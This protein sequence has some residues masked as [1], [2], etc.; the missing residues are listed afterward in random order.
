MQQEQE[1]D[2]DHEQQA[3]QEL[4]DALLHAGDPYMSPSPPASPTFTQRTLG[5][6]DEWEE[7]KADEEISSDSTDATAHTLTGMK[8]KGH[9][10]PTPMHV[11]SPDA[12]EHDRDQPPHTSHLYSGWQQRGP[13]SISYDPTPSSLTRPL[14][15]DSSGG[16][17]GLLPFRIR[18][19]TYNDVKGRWDEDG[20]GAIPSQQQHGPGRY[21]AP[22]RN[23]RGQSGGLEE[24]PR[25]PPMKVDAYQRTKIH[26]ACMNVSSA[27]RGSAC[28]LMCLT[29]GSFLSVH[30]H[31]SV[32]LHK[33]TH[34]RATSASSKPPSRTV[35]P[36]PSGATVATTSSSG[37]RGPSRRSGR[38]TPLR[39]RKWMRSLRGRR[40]CLGTRRCSRPPAAGAYLPCV[41]A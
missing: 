5:G 32:P 8:G 33:Y 15:G 1:L 23:G 41:L 13:Y 40:R 19:N 22:G 31:T 7:Q 9:R 35:T 16:S 28:M 6:S 26:E 14:A 2:Y 37:G 39:G 12:H 18:P 36:R 3:K 38:R 11:S 4:V 21:V 20:S 27:S 34:H 10:P 25:L 30:L 17:G 29:C 24:G